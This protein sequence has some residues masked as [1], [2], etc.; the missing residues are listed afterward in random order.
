MRRAVYLLPLCG[1]GSMAPT[2]PEPPPGVRKNT[3]RNTGVAATKAGKSFLLE[4]GK[5][6]R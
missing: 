5:P 2:D 6:K 1:C 4:Q 3:E